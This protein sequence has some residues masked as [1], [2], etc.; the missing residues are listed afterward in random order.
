MS[1]PFVVVLLLL[2]LLPQA[3]VGGESERPNILLILSDD[4]G[5]GDLAVYGNQDVRTPHLDRLAQQSVLFRNFHAQP[6]CS[7]TRA[8][9]MTGRNFLEAGVWGVHG[10]RD[11]LHLDQRTIANE[12]N[13]SGYD[14]AM[15][16]KWHLG[17]T[18][19]YM[20][21]NRG[22]NESW[23]ITGRLYEHTDPILDHS[24]TPEHPRG[25]AADILTEL[26]IE[27][28]T[29]Q[30]ES[31]FFVYLAYP[32]VHEPWV[33]PESL[34]ERYEQ[35]GL[36]RSM[37]SVYA[38]N[39][40]LDA[41]VGRLLLAMEE[42]GLG[43]N[44]VVVFVGDNGPINTTSNGLSPLTAAEMARRNPEGLRGMKGQVFEN[45]LRVPA[46]IRWSGRFDP[47]EVTVPADVID[48][49]PTLLDIAGVTPADPAKLRGES[50]TPLLTGTDSAPLSR[51]AFYAN[52]EAIWPARKNLYSFLPDKSHI[53][54]FRT[55]LAVR[56]GKFKLV[57][58]DGERQLFDIESDPREHTDLSRAAPRRLSGA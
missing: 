24:G 36:S 39:E 49:A 37:A 32:E 50:L 26:A 2:V 58:I 5:Y 43:E 4:Q 35:Q 16:G 7:P 17:K 12:L 46:M 15:L 11:Y 18:A 8:E 31:P 38:M 19:P 25:W 53:D 10:G 48:L 41:A 14:T 54:P 21:Y 47:R 55:H 23:S 27:F 42:H 3:V 20:P 34:I 45:G 9:L 22:F 1:L 44:T 40:Q 13:D 52:H 28:M 57:Q 29:R 56:S 30:R 33:A 51:P 6:V